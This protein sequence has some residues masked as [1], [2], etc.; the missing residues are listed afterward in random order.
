MVVKGSLSV[1]VISVVVD[2]VVAG[3]VDGMGVVRVDS[4][5]S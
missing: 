4:D 5:S 2:D 1:V 3:V